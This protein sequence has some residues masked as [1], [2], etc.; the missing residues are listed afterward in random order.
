MDNLPA[1]L[2]MIVREERKLMPPKDP[3]LEMPKRLELPILGTATQQLM[4]SD[5]TARVDEEQ[6]RKEADKL[7]KQR[8][9]RGKGSNFLSCN[10]S[11]VWNWMS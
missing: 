10:H 5:A 6:F 9:A 4:E 1:H 7:Q 8:V 3:A 11:I 2:R